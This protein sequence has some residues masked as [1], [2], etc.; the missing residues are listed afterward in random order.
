MI[1]I[2][3]Y[4]F[5]IQLYNIL[6]ICR[7]LPLYR[8]FVDLEPLSLGKRCFQLP[9]PPLYYTP[10]VM[11][12]VSSSSAWIALVVLVR[13]MPLLQSQDIFYK[14]VNKIYFLLLT[15]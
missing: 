9:H 7:L 10:M 8:A 15:P 5:R 1:Q 2:Q 11:T 12:V 6:Y 13:D 3:P 4:Y 14:Y